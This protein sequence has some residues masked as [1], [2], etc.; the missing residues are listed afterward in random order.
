MLD[1]PSA[2]EHPN[3][4]GG[5]GR[6]TVWSYPE[7]G[8][9][10]LPAPRAA[11]PVVAHR[12]SASSRCASGISARRRAP[13]ATSRA[14]KAGAPEPAGRPPT[15]CSATADS[16][17]CAPLPR[18]ATP[19]PLA[20]ARTHRVSPTSTEPLRPPSCSRCPSTPTRSP[21]GT[22]TRRSPPSRESDRKI[23]V[24]EPAPAGPPASKRQVTLRRPRRRWA[25]RPRRDHH[26]HLRRHAPRSHLR[27]ARDHHRPRPGGRARPLRRRQ[28]R[29]REPPRWLAREFG[30]STGTAS[31]CPARRRPR[32]CWRG[33]AS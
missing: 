2:G 22:W 17:P 23:L 30:A 8:V 12:P 24:E 16:Q 33:R 6:R 21:R 7:G 20:P 28:A 14:T 11:G 19:L 27:R 18:R 15:P 29:G 5:A 10:A 3:R 4:R 32:R 9:P 26:L 25:A 13:G 31:S 1:S